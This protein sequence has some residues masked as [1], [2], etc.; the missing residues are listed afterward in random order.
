MTKTLLFSVEDTARS[1]GIGRSSLYLLIAEGK[2][3]TVKIGRRTL[4][5]EDEITRYVEDLSETRKKQ[6]A[7]S[8]NDRL[9]RARGSEQSSEA[10]FSELE[11]T[12]REGHTG[13]GR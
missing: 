8:N 13:D 10:F 6:N 4:I 2:I 12:T 9:F 5:R 7:G 3:A 11:P 1:L